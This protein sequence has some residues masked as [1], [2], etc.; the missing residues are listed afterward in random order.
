MVSAT[1]QAMLAL[2]I[3]VIMFGM[4]ASLTPR[5][6]RRALKKPQGI[7]IGMSSQFGF[8][9]FI[10][11]GMA[12]LLNL[13]PEQ[14]IGLILMGC[15]PGGTTSNIFTYFSKGDLALSI[16]MTVCSTIVAV[17]MT[18]TLLWL[19]GSTFTS[20]EMQIP[21]KNIAVT[22]GAMLIPVML[23]MVVRRKNANIAATSELLGGLLGI[24]VIVFLIVSWVPR[25]SHLLSIT[26]WS[27]YVAAVMLGLF[28]IMFGYVVSHQL[29]LGGKRTRTVAL[30]T[31]IQN[32][33]LG[34]AIVLLSFQQPL[35]DKV[36]LVPV[37]YS[38]FIVL[39]AAMVTILFRRIATRQEMASVVIA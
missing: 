14:A 4:G 13:S 19:Y 7:L 5:D 11:W 30:E 26:P 21:I 38:L 23:A 33:P 3:I 29:K 2:M 10:A 39:T 6:F 35:A 37:L 31:G 27:V 36:L 1:E 15:I 17:V 20:A 22:L 24:L 34:V 12:Y 25:N 18:P 9:P 32:G 28:G 16:T 8:M